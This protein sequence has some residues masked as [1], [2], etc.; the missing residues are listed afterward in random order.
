MIPLPFSFDII[1]AQINI[2]TILYGL[3]IGVE[4]ILYLDVGDIFF[5]YKFQ[6]TTRMQ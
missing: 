3:F 1:K 5:F 2:A 6:L 4:I